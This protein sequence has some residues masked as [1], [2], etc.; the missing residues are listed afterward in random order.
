MNKNT[1]IEMLTEVFKC[2][3]INGS[4]EESLHPI[5][6]LI[7]NASVFHFTIPEKIDYRKEMVNENS[8]DQKLNLPFESTIILSGLK[9]SDSEIAMYIMRY[10]QDLFIAQIIKSKRRHF[11][12]CMMI[13]EKDFIPKSYSLGAKSAIF[14]Y[15]FYPE[16]K[17]INH[18]D[19]KTQTICNALTVSSA[20]FISMSSCARHHLVKVGPTENERKGRSVEWIKSKEH[21]LVL[22]PEHAK[23]VANGTQKDF[24]GTITRAMHQRRGHFRRL[25]HERFTKKKGLRIW[26]NASWV[27]PKEWLGTDKKIYIVQEKARIFPFENKP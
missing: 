15:Q 7:K 17:L 12:V 27:G 2:K 19:E 4:T 10:K 22:G 18:N 21:Y 20:Y 5:L 1:V 13:D 9:I 6:N 3:E 23:A 14:E 24:N 11:C 8:F 26:V 16:R 25:T